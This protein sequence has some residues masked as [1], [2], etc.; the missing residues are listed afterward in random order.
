MTSSGS[1]SIRKELLVDLINKSI[2][3]TFRG[4]GAIVMHKNRE[5]FRYSKGNIPELNFSYNENVLFDMASLTKPIIT[6]TLAMKLLDANKIGLDDPISSYL[7]E[8]NGVYFDK[9]SMK[10][11][12]SHSS[13]LIPSYPLYLN[14]TTREDYLKTIRAI[15][16]GATPYTKEEYSDLNYILL[17]LI[18]EEITGKTLNELATEE[19]LK[20]L[21]MNS[22]GFKPSMDKKLIAPTEKTEERGQIWGEVHDENAYYLGGIAGHA[23]FFSTLDDMAKYVVGFNESKLFSRKTKELMVTPV[24]EFLGGNFGLGWMI[25]NSR[26]EKS[27]PSFGYTAFMGDYS[28]YGTIG[29]TGFTGTSI[30]MDLKR[31]LTVV[32]LCNRVYPTR[33]NNLMLRFRRIFHNAVYNS[34][35]DEEVG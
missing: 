21:K 18:L 20:P 31:N 6:A 25:K 9:F 19:I 22:S 16:T 32:I 11:L 15:S 27:G 28:S 4:L 29:H 8:K 24:N 35:N 33:E 2:P 13:G 1:I 23:G 7:K 10:N 26:S 12:L 30:V 34:I 17:G 3:D 5:I 14:G